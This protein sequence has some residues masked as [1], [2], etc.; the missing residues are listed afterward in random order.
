MEWWIPK[1]SLKAP[2]PKLRHV[3]CSLE[4]RDEQYHPWFVSARLFCVSRNAA[5]I[6]V[7]SSWS[8]SPLFSPLFQN[9]RETRMTLEWHRSTLCQCW[10]YVSNVGASKDQNHFRT[11][12]PSLSR[13]LLLQTSCE[14]NMGETRWRLWGRRKKTLRG[15]RGVSV[16][17]PMVTRAKGRYSVPMILS[18][19]RG[20]LPFSFLP[21]PKVIKDEESKMSFSSIISRF[22]NPKVEHLVWFLIGIF[23]FFFWSFRTLPCSLPWS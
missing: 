8:V 13:L 5:A 12:Q 9:I 6:A 22:L 19:R 7:Q 2:L 17:P 14:W 4:S 1:L 21:P 23:F 15:S 11:C 10:W 18:Q 20:F 16:C 3:I